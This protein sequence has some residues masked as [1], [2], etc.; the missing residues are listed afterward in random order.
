MIGGVVSDGIEPLELAP[1][2]ARRV[3]GLREVGS[4][5]EEPPKLD[6]RRLSGLCVKSSATSARGWPSHNRCNM[7]P[8]CAGL[9]FGEDKASSRTL[10][11][12][13][14]DRS[15]ATS[16][17]KFAL[18]TRVDARYTQ[19]TA[20]SWHARQVFRPSPSHFRFL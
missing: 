3:R 20:A 15:L 2:L 14:I 5:A 18:E 4:E 6:P 13:L 10:L 9:V 16:S 11:S 8:S 19:S 1:V 17:R 12:E 7:S